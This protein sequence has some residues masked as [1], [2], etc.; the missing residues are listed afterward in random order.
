MKATGHLRSQ[1]TNEFLTEANKWNL[2][3]H[4]TEHHRGPHDPDEVITL[5]LSLQ[6]LARL[7]DILR[8]A[9]GETWFDPDHGYRSRPVDWR[10]YNARLATERELAASRALLY[11]QKLGGS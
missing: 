10:S 1:T 3:G 9:G 5:E 4:L 11:T 7:A 8:H 2:D 6:Q